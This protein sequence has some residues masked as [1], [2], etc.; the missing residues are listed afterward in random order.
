M[1]FKAAGISPYAF[2][3]AVARMCVHA[4]EPVIMCFQTSTIYKLLTMLAVTTFPAMA[5]AYVGPGAGITAI[6]S[7]LALLMGIV[8]AI[9][10]FIWYPLKRFIRSRTGKTGTENTAD[11]PAA[12]RSGNQEKY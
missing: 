10:G 12:G 1:Q 7:V 11:K 5:F 6:G 3:P 8:L 2:H 9:V 4:E